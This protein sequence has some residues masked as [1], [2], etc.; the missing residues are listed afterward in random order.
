MIVGLNVA[1]ET[2]ED[3]NWRAIGAIAAALAFAVVA[4]VSLGSASPAAAESRVSV[5]NS[6]GSAAIDPTYM[7]QLQLSGSGFQ[8]V[9][10]GHGGIYVLFGAIKG[11]WQPSKGGSSGTNYFTVPDSESKNNGGYAKFV[12]FPGS[13]TADSANGGQISSDGSWSTTMNVPGATFKT[14]DRSGKATTIDCRKM[15][16]GVITIGAH[17]V[18]NAKNETFTRVSVETL[19]GA[20]SATPAPAATTSGDPAAGAEPGVV[21]AVA[22][23][24][25]PTLTIDRASARPG[26]IV[27]FSADGLAPGTQVN[28]T[29]AD[30]LAAAGPLTV[31]SSGQ[32]AGLI[33]LPGSVKPGTY[34]LR[35]IGRGDMPRARF[36]VINAAASAAGVSLLPAVYATAGF[37]SLF[38]AVAFGVLR[39]RR[40]TLEN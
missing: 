4:L 23:A 8:S 2:E 7:T 40:S 12:T 31:S 25:K 28:A 36:A 3:R 22:A 38:G 39:W 18:T 26:R 9:K 27:A 10:N 6:Q 32:V 17:G 5:R 20:G 29:F 21:P 35:L 33:E 30:G 15:T 14:L 11:T 16:C 13:D 19:S 1:Y 34:E 24:G 37:L